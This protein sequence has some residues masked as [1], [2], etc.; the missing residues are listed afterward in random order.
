MALDEAIRRREGA[1]M[2]NSPESGREQWPASWASPNAPAPSPE[3]DQQRADTQHLDSPQARDQ[4]VE[5]RRGGEEPVDDT[6]RFDPPHD[7]QNQ[8]AP[9][10]AQRAAGYPATDPSGYP[11]AGSSAYPAAGSAGHPRAG[12][13]ALPPR[14]PA[15]AVGRSAAVRPTRSAAGLSVG[16]GGRPARARLGRCGR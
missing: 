6:Q 8:P 16:P 14:G 1:E 4:Q 12:L 10:Y 9:E 7:P 13:P 5:G 11:S 15:L 3:V 2:S